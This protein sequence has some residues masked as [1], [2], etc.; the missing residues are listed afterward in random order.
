MP[1]FDEILQEER[2]KVRFERVLKE[3]RRKVA[4]ERGLLAPT[5]TEAKAMREGQLNMQSGQ[6]LGSAKEALGITA[7]EDNP[8]DRGVARQAQRSIEQGRAPDEP[9]LLPEVRRFEQLAAAAQPGQKIVPVAGVAQVQD[10]SGRPLLQLRRGAAVPSDVY[11]D[12]PWTEKAMGVL[13]GAADVVDKGVATLMRNAAS[14]DPRFGH[15]PGY[16][17]DEGVSE[18]LQKWGAS[19]GEKYPAAASALNKPAAALRTG[20]NALGYAKDKFD[21]SDAEQKAMFQRVTTDE[22]KKYRGKLSAED[23]AAAVTQDERDGSRAADDVAAAKQELAEQ[24]RDMRASGAAVMR[25]LAKSPA[26]GRVEG[27]DIG[28]FAGDVYD[29]VSPL[30]TANLA[31]GALG[32]VARAA[33]KSRTLGDIA[34]GVAGKVGTKRG[35]ERG[36]LSA[37]PAAVG[38]P[39]PVKGVIKAAESYAREFPG[40]EQARLA[41]A[42]GDYDRA[43]AKQVQDAW[44]DPAARTALVK[45]RPE[46]L[47]MFEQAQPRHLEV[48][49]ASGVK[50]KDYN[51]FHVYV[52]QDPSRRAE[53][54]RTA[55]AELLDHEPAKKI[56]ERAGV[57]SDQY[58]LGAARA[59]PDADFTIPRGTNIPG[60]GALERDPVLRDLLTI[61]AVPQEGA[62]PNAL[63]GSRFLPGARAADSKAQRAANLVAGE[64][65]KREQSPKLSHLFQ[66]VTGRAMDDS[67]LEDAARQIMDQD[68][69]SGLSGSM[70]SAASHSPERSAGAMRML[71]G[72]GRN[73]AFDE[74]S[75]IVAKS[76]EVYG[77]EAFT[78]LSSFMERRPHI[79]LAS[80]PPRLNAYGDEQM[81]D[82]MQRELVIPSAMRKELQSKDMV[83]VIPRGSTPM[84]AGLAE[85]ISRAHYSKQQHVVAIPGMQWSEPKLVPRRVVEA[86]LQITSGAKDDVVRN[87]ADDIEF[88]L[89]AAQANARVTQGNPGFTLRNILA[90]VVR[91]AA[92]QG[93]GFLTDKAGRRATEKWMFQPENRRVAEQLLG[94]G[95]DLGRRGSAFGVAP[96]APGIYPAPLRRLQQKAFNAT[97]AP[98]Q[99]LNEAADDAFK[100]NLFP[101]APKNYTADDVLRVHHFVTQVRKGVDP[102]TAALNTNSLLINYA[103]K[104]SGERV[105]KAIFPFIRYYTGALQGALKLSVEQPYRFTRLNNL[106]TFAENMQGT[107]IGDDQAV[108]AKSKRAVDILTGMPAVRL[109]RDDKALVLRPETPATEGL[110]VID[111]L[112][113]MYDPEMASKADSGFFSLVG[114]AVTGGFLSTVA[115]DLMTRATGHRPMSVGPELWK[116]LGNATTAGTLPERT[117]AL[118]ETINQKPGMGEGVAGSPGKAKAQIAWDLAKNAPLLERLIPTY[119]DAL[120]RSQTQATGYTS[121][122]PEG[123]EMALWRLLLRSTTGQRTQPL[124]IQESMAEKSRHMGNRPLT[125]QEMMNS[126]GQGRRP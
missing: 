14:D 58:A 30:Q 88:A 62:P 3:E 17:D 45:E 71:F 67:S 94:V 75:E 64:L 21:L 104:S 32:P 1:T 19:A 51:P 22:A 31:L 105:A 25:P 92:D 41:D 2:R 122:T 112:M 36:L 89:G 26:E 16:R 65:A 53:L 115:P 78:D 73:G 56:L 79:P 33:G 11:K 110:A 72:S 102:K 117:K 81:R 63:L 100:A 90:N 124:D 49:L 43:L 125:T 91:G 61:R 5:P 20:L 118:W 106:A 101:S 113:A 74:A 60:L 68:V 29:L 24:E 77:P 34:E 126:I 13:T 12:Q 52:G 80:F 96:V 6:R 121:R 54:G 123:A 116:A 7:G 38:A 85:D 84:G 8:I 23:Y 18:V 120:V 107:A 99:S 4:E 50:P 111:P 109:G 86:S 44:S 27:E 119:A 114:P 37:T 47:A 66:R 69:V 15:M 82:F 48:A 59:G 103:D 40:L 108:N 98:G 97:N 57:A 83:L 42:F 35:T 28:T 95:K 70:R 87:L 10:D 9:T 93:G 46:A 55:S 76:R 39:V